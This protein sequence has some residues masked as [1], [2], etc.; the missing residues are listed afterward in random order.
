MEVVPFMEEGDYTAWFKS[1]SI[2]RF[3]TTTQVRGGSSVGAEKERLY[4]MMKDA[5]H[6]AQPP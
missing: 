2:G 1:V 5:A 4:Q 3:T 6:R